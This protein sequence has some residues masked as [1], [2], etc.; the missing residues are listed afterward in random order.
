M[1]HARARAQLY[2]VQ[3]FAKFKFERLCRAV[4]TPLRILRGSIIWPDWSLRYWPDT[5][6]KYWP[7]T[8]LKY[9]PDTGLKYQPDMG[10]KYRPVTGRGFAGCQLGSDLVTTD[11]VSRRLGLQADDF[12][13]NREFFLDGCLNNLY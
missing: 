10:L 4:V 8:G 3:I 5:G 13:F 9:Q 7:N 11:L 1:A 12:V 2:A 6:R